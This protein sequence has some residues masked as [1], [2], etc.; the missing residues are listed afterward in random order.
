[1][2]PDRG[3]FAGPGTASPARRAPGLARRT[4]DGAAARR[5][6]PAPGRTPSSAGWFTVGSWM[7]GGWREIDAW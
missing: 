1:M 5:H 4:G 3:R 7:T 2:A 6:L